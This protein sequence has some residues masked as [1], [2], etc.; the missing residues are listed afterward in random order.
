MVTFGNREVDIGKSPSFFRELRVFE[1]Y[2]CVIFFLKGNFENKLKLY[3]KELA[4]EN[5]AARPARPKVYINSSVNLYKVHIAILK[6]L[7][8]PLDFTLS[9]SVIF[10]SS[11]YI[12][13]FKK[14]LLITEGF[15]LQKP[16][17]ER[18]S[19]QIT[20]LLQSVYSSLLFLSP[21]VYYTPSMYLGK[22]N[23]DMVKIITGN[24]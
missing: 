15:L 19:K 11:S 20:D 12:F 18:C 7:R 14:Q 4:N 6:L 22:K 8:F 17:S 24:I 10:E 23:H 16:S 5:H 13:F 9:L 1:F 21:P 2:T 3:W